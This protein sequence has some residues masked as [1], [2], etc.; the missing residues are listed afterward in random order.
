MDLPGLIPVEH[1]TRPSIIEEE[2]SELG[3]PPVTS[4]LVPNNHSLYELTCDQ[5]YELAPYE[6]S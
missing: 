2:V 3:P 4:E 5:K 6:Q 1:L